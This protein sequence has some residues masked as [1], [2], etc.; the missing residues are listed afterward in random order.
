MFV[1][2]TGP[3]SSAERSEWT[4]LADEKGTISLHNWN[5]F[6]VS[7]STT[8]SR[9][10]IEVISALSW[11]YRIFSSWESWHSDAVWNN[12]FCN[13]VNCV[14]QITIKMPNLVLVFGLTI[15]LLLLLNNSG[16]ELYRNEWNFNNNNWFN[17]LFD[18]CTANGQN[19]QLDLRECYACSDCPEVDPNT[20]P[21]CTRA[22]QNPI[23]PLDIR[24]LFPESLTSRSCI[25]I[26]DKCSYHA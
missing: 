19:Q 9:L 10:N 6:I 2:R 12:S 14:I 17:W 3:S 23:V 20:T 25:K 4:K 8:H 16:T 21:R 24:F 13:I 15:I 22:S 1:S 11:S 18:H 26:T 7:I 5:D